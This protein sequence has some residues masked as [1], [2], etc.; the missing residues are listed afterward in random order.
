MIQWRKAGHLGLWGRKKV[1]RVIDFGKESLFNIKVFCST[2][3]IT[4][5]RCPKSQPLQ[6]NV[7]DDSM[8]KSVSSSCLRQMDLERRT[9]M[10]K[11]WQKKNPFSSLLKYLSPGIEVVFVDLLLLLYFYILNSAAACNSIKKRNFNYLWKKW[12]IIFVIVI[13]TAGLYP[14]APRT[15]RRP[16][17]TGS[18]I[19]V[20]FKFNALAINY[21]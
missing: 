17:E 2:K 8:T 13:V 16:M 5:Y 18:S 1:R 10:F 12:K 9:R 11:F 3:E 14:G 20:L 4:N 15:F 6:W 21:F 7:L 19:Y